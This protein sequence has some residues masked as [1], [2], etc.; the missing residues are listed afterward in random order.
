MGNVI[1]LCKQYQCFNR[2]LL[3][4]L[5]ILA[6]LHN[7]ELYILPTKIDIDYP[8]KLPCSYQ[9]E[10]G[11]VFSNF[12]RAIP[13]QL[14]GKS[15]TITAGQYPIN[16]AYNFIDFVNIQRWID[17]IAQILDSWKVFVNNSKLVLGVELG[18]IFEYVSSNS[19]KSDI[20]N[21]HLQIVNDTNPKFPLTN[22]E[23][24]SDQCNRS[25]YAYLSWE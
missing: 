12:L 9:L 19:I 16:I 25:S 4:I 10:F 23:L 17:K 13:T 7:S 14:G 6:Y 2:Y 22:N 5:I 11:S 3:P 18:D 20:E 24:I 1:T 21:Q 15:L 8:F